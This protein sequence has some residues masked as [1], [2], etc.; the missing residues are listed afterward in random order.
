[1]TQEEYIAQLADYKAKTDYLSLS[2]SRLEASNTQYQATNDQLNTRIDHL[3]A[4]IDQLNVTISQLNDNV[5]SKE[6]VIQQ[7]LLTISDLRAQI[8]RLEEKKN[9]NSRNSSK[10]PSSDGLS[11]PPAPP[12][13]PSGK[14][15]GG[16]NGH[17]GANLQINVE[18]TESVEHKPSACEQCP[19]WEKCKGVACVAETRSVADI[20]VEIS[21]TAH[22]A[23][24]LPCCKL[25]G[26]RIRGEFPENIKATIQYGTNLQALTAALNTVGAVSVNRTHE[27]LQGVFGIPIATGT[28][29]NIVKRTAK[30]V[31]PACEKIKRDI[32]DAQLAHFDE[33]GTRM[34]GKTAWVH[35]ASNSEYTCLDISRKRGK[36]GMDQC[37]VLPDY[38]GIA[39]HDCWKSY[40]KYPDIG[41]H[42]VCCAHILRELTGIIENNPKQTWA[43][44]MKV[45]LLKMKKAR[46]N[47]VTAGKEKLSDS[48][49]KQLLLQ[50]DRIIG[51][52]KFQ[53]PIPESTG[54]KRG[55]PKKGKARAL[56]DRL[57]EL[58]ASVC[59][60][61]TNFAVPF[62]NN[63]AERDLRNVKT[64]TKVSGCFRTEDG[65]R[66]Y[67]K[68]MSYVG[69]A[70]KR[71]KNAYTAICEALSGNPLYIFE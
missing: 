60:F 69:T 47:A 28:V 27:I 55:R 5:A 30:A 1:M 50:Y 40:W 45:T 68:I 44:Q 4:S 6:A 34:E 7:L 2:N 26:E 14:N 66:D 16:Q 22:N 36:K 42:A 39:V 9:K 63:Q 10:P 3:Q 43:R 64:K 12:R 20:S 15:K 21:V 18:P 52:G 11:K 13:K 41:D 49:L 65:A 23:L 38:H 35:N 24:E 19:L 37:G 8:A 57:E 70:H 32:T 46:D 48:Y 31:T 61:L 29:S 58:K 25:G 67:L 51:I 53:N 71:R 62:D 56:V 59:L 33:T 17:P 54:Q